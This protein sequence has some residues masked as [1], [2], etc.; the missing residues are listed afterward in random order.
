MM[1]PRPGAYHLRTEAGRH[2]VDLLF[3]MS[4][5]RVVALEFKAG[6]APGVGDAKHLIWLRDRLGADFLAGAVIHSGPA[7]FE[8]AERV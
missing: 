1:Y 3:D 7:V 5:G 6:A 8:L 2:E 4:G